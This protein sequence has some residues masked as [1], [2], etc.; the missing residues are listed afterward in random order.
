MATREHIGIGNELNR[1]VQASIIK[2]FAQ[3]E[4]AQLSHSSFDSSATSIRDGTEDRVTIAYPIGYKPSREP[5]IGTWTYDRDELIARF[6]YRSHT[7][8][9]TN[10]IYQLAMLVET[11]LTDLIRRLV[12]EYPLHHDRSRVNNCHGSHFVGRDEDVHFL[13]RGLL[14]PTSILCTAGSVGPERTDEQRCADRRK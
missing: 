4:L 7:Q 14:E 8:I 11:M 13:Y 2:T 10:G 3:A 5:M 9:P 12:L 6:S 1:I